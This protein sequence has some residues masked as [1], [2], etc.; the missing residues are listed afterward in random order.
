MSKF[1]TD[2]LVPGALIAG[3]ID[4]ADIS[5]PGRICL[6]NDFDLAGLTVNFSALLNP[7]KRKAEVA[8]IISK[9]FT[10]VDHV[11]D[12]IGQARLDAD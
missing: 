2:D 6:K 7:G 12:V 4:T 5:T 10:G 3:N 1:S 11:S 8:E 9:C